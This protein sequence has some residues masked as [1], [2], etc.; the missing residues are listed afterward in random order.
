MRFAIRLDSAPLTVHGPN[1]QAGSNQHEREVAVS[2]TG[3]LERSWEPGPRENAYNGADCPVP[4]TKEAPENYPISEH[5]T[6]TKGQ[7][8]P[9]PVLYWN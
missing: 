8:P 6:Q 3:L 2:E 5:L 9:R 1:R 4:V 7:F